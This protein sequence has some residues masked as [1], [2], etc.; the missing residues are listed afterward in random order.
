MNVPDL[1]TLWVGRAVLVL[2]ILWL[3]AIV[4]WAVGDRL[5]WRKLP[6]RWKSGYLNP[7][8]R[9]SLVAT[10]VGFVVMVI[11]G[12]PVGW[13]DAPSVRVVRFKRVKE[14]R[15][16]REALRKRVDGEREEGW[17]D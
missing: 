12:G 9:G 5:V 4:W 8:Y 13:L 10:P 1:I 3:I 2:A 14:Y 11:L 6:S 16:E 7:Y 15:A 17:F